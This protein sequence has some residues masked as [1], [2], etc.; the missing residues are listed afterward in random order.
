[1]TPYLTDA[2]HDLAS[3]AD[4]LAATKVDISTQTPFTI[5]VRLWTC[6]DRCPM[7]AIYL[8]WYEARDN[9]RETAVCR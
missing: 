9:L 7:V 8:A 2:H 4:E 1:M 6:F 3:G 5:Q